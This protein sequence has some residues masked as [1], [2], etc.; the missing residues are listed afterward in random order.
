MADIR[1]PE[2]LQE[3]EGVVL[4]IERGVDISNWSGLIS[5]EE[6]KCWKAHDQRFVV[7][8]T[9]RRGTARQQLD[10]A[11][12]VGLGVEAYVYLYWAYNVPAQVRLALDTIRGFPVKRLWIDCEADASA[13]GPERSV[14]R[15]SALEALIRQAVRACGDFPCGIYTGYW[16][17]GPNMLGCDEFTNLPLWVALYNGQPR[18]DN[19]PDLLPG[20]KP[21]MKQYTNTTSLCDVSVCK[22]CREEATE[23]PTPEERIAAIEKEIRNIRVGMA[24][25]N[26]ARAYH[27]ADKAVHLNA[28]YLQEMDERLARIGR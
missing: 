22:D 18:L 21:T 12:G 11:S 17:W 13:Y 19:C 9:Q 2:G 27:E 3:G 1:D 25:I 15:A 16:W 28:Q 20:W 23:V 5:T 14:E 4:M 26:A 8:G 10:V 6:A 7:C 24:W